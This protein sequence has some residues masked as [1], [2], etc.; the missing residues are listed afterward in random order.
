MKEIGRGQYCVVWRARDKN[1]ANNVVAMKFFT[2]DEDF[3]DLIEREKGIFK[4]L[5]EAPFTPACLG[6]FSK[7]PTLVLENFR[8]DLCSLLA[9]RGPMPLSRMQCGTVQLLLALEH[10]HGLMLAHGDIKPENILINSEGDLILSDFGGCIVFGSSEDSFPCVT[11][12]YQPPEYILDDE[13]KKHSD[14]WSLGIVCAQMIHGDHPFEVAAEEEEIDQTSPSDFMQF[15]VDEDQEV[16]ENA[17]L[18]QQGSND[19]DDQTFTSQWS[20]EERLQ[21][22]D[23]EFDLLHRI[24][25]RLGPYPST[26]AQKHKDVFNEKGLVQGFSYSPEPLSQLI[27][28]SKDASSVT[29]EAAIRLLADMLTYEPK[30]RPTCTQLLEYRVLTEALRLIGPVRRLKN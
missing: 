25:I 9:A 16:S 22:I 10:M 17:P 3:S 28:V 21:D 15:E 24:S 6:S 8:G 29:L 2:N 26:W 18:L 4:K 27:R 14:V 7:P 11:F 12:S 19:D 5:H 30:Q 20:F 23:K 1:A 13:Y